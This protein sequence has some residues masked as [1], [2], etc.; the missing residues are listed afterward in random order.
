MILDNKSP[1]TL[2]PGD[3]AKL[4]KEMRRIQEENKILKRTF[5]CSQK[6]RRYRALICIKCLDA[7]Y[8]KEITLC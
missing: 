7:R 6:N 4:Q 2:V 3:Y 1:I 5:P 8:N